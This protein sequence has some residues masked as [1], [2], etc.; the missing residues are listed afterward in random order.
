MII[1]ADTMRLYRPIA[2]NITNEHISVYINEAEK[3]DI[4]PAIGAALYRKFSSL[5]LVAVRPKAQTPAGK[6][7]VPAAVDEQLQP[8][9]AATVFTGSEGDLPADEYKLLN[10]GYYDATGCGAEDCYFAG[11][12]AALA[13]LAYAR[14]LR[15]HAL[16]VTP[17]GV[18]VKEGDGSSPA[19]PQA[20]NAAATDADKVGREYLGQTLAWWKSVHTD[21]KPAGPRRRFIAIGD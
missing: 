19:T 3:L 1:N 17:F 21:A 18:V 6:L 12:K 16:N 8:A 9:A 2:K 7:T 11:I 13:Y 15:N 4:L 14:F 10:G 5:G 20:I